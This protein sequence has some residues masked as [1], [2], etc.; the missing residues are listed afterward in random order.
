MRRHPD[1]TIRTPEAVTA[2]SSKVTEKDI[3]NWFRN[4]YSYL[5]DND[6]ADILL[7]P[8][9]VLNGDETGFSLNPIPKK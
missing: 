1:L 9:R 7:D 3:R 8:A 5:E 6:W 4:V 2:A